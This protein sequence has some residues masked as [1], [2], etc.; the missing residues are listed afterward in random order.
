[1]LNIRTPIHRSKH[2]FDAEAH[3]AI[4]RV[5]EEMAAEDPGHQPALDAWRESNAMIDQWEQEAQERTAP[6]ASEADSTTPVPST[7]KVRPARKVR[8]VRKAQSARKVA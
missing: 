3:T 7:R 5:L 4:E 2:E 1:M 6:A 8:S